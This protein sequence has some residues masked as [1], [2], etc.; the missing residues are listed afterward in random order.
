MT[1]GPESDDRSVL[2][3][4]FRILG[5]FH[6]GRTRLTLSELA[7]HAGIAPATAHR[8][9]GQLVD[10]GALVRAPDGSYELGPRIFELG[11]LTARSR[12]LRQIALPH[13]HD[14][15][16]ATGH[17]VHLVVREGLD[18]RYLERL[19]GPDSVP[20]LSRSGGRVPIHACSG[21]LTLLA[22]AKPTLV[23]QVLVRGLE[24][25]TPQTVCTRND[26]LSVLAHVRAT[27]RAICVDQMVVGTTSMAAALRSPT[28]EVVAAVSVVTA[29]SVDTA[30]LAVAL[31]MATRSISRQLPG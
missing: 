10:N 9:T 11:S 30:S 16:V 20:T 5:T 8:M 22:F 27:G 3:R 31:E 1:T 15:H 23:Q 29:N 19:A 21:G 24:Q 2:G 6:A 28:G 13:L 12:S 26:L 17:C 4:A 7:R 25:L 18:A 14:L